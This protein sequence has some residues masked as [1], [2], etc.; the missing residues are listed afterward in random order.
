[1]PTRTFFRCVTL[2]VAGFL[3][4]TPAWA[5]PKPDVELSNVEVSVGITINAL[6][7]DVNALP[8]CAQ[9]S[10]PCTHTKPNRFGGFGIDLSVAH[11]VSPNVAIVSGASAFE[12]SWTS[13][14]ASSTHRQATT[15][16]T[17]VAIG[18]RISTDFF[19]APSDPHPGRLFAQVLLGAELSNA[20]TLRPSPHLK[21]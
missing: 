17:A 19:Y 15:R 10:L 4:E 3:M 2:L 16:V 21:S 1:V 11:A 7:Q 6:F 13:P 20:G 12:T 8:T 9:L 14:D 5:Q 18:P